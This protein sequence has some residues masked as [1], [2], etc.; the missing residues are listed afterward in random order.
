[1][2]SARERRGMWWLDGYPRPDIRGD[3]AAVL[4]ACD[5]ELRRVGVGLSEQ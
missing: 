1:M 4:A 5:A 3:L 2:T